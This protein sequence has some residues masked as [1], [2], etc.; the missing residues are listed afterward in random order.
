ML[1][2]APRSRAP[3]GRGVQPLLKISDA[4]LVGVALDVVDAPG[5]RDADA[6]QHAD[7]EREED[8]RQRDD[9]V[10]EIEHGPLP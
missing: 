4:S 9:V 7:D 5:L 8:R 6:E 3:L 2:A 10:S 1:C